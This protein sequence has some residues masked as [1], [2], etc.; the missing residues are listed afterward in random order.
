MGRITF[1]LFKDVVPKT[2][3]NFRQFCTG[4]SKA[5]SGKP[6]GY[7]NSR[8]HRIVCHLSLC[9]RAGLLDMTSVRVG[10]ADSELQDS[11]LHV[12]GRRLPPRRRNRVDLYLWKQELCRRELQSE[13]R[14]AGFAVHG[15]MFAF[16][17][18]SSSHLRIRHHRP[19]SKSHR[20]RP[21]TLSST[22]MSY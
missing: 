3:E 12:P 6:Q 8:F 18:L 13:A 5:T 11:Q 2:A 4:E 20:H 1:E 19:T 16:A 21:V 14:P 22:A 15:C 17:S 10:W 7:K 9:I